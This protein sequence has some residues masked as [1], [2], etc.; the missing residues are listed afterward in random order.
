MTELLAHGDCNAPVMG[1]LAWDAGFL[2]GS[3]RQLGPVEVFGRCPNAR[4]LGL[5]PDPKN[6]NLLS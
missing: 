3:A 4:V 2:S 5:N 6:A 1:H